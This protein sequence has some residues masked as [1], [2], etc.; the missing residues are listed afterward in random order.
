VLL[1][2]TLTMVTFGLPT[3]GAVEAQPHPADPAF[4]TCIAEST[5]GRDRKELAKW[6]FYAMAAH[7]E[8]KS[9]VTI[10]DADVQANAKVIAV[11]VNR[12]LTEAC[13]KETRAVLHGNFPSALE[14]AFE[15]LGKLA[16]LELMGDSAAKAGLNRWLEFFDQ[17]QLMEKLGEK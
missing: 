9:R 11:L 2:L 10:V 3:Q 14:L 13:L 4:T 7:S 12:L 15:N 6:I 16:M 8:I 1:Q 5:T 17:K